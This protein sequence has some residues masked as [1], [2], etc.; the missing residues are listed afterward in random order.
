MALPLMVAG[1]GCA[2]ARVAV[3]AERTQY[4]VSLSGVVRDREGA[5][6]GAPA[7]QKVGNFAAGKTAYGIVH[8]TVSLSGSWDLSDEINRQV[9]AAGGE[10]VINLRIAA[11]D[12]C[13]FLNS[14]LIFN[15]LPIWPGCAPLEASGDI[16]VRR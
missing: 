13:A 12:H 15:A 14:V 4:P 8:S 9:K 1:S 7:L 10:A 5:L 6:L 11:T 16:V 3:T 2:G